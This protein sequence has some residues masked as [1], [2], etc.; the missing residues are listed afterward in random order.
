MATHLEQNRIND[1]T[2]IVESSGEQG[3]SEDQYVARY[4]ISP[5]EALKTP[6]KKK[7]DA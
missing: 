2:V 7:E 3:L 6:S 1:A 4:G 5:T